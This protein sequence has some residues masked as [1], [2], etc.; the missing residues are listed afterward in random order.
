MKEMQPS[1]EE[2]RELLDYDPTT[3]ELHWKVRRNS[4]VA[5]GQLAGS[6]NNEG[7][8]VVGIFRKVYQAHRIAWLIYYGQWPSDQLDH[9]NHCRTDN[10]ITNLR[11]V[12][13]TSNLRNKRK[14][15]ANTSGTTGVYKTRAGNWIARICVGRETLNLGTF[16]SIDL[17][18]KA[19]NEANI[20]HRFHTNHG[21]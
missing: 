7:Y 16:P 5:E 8:L 19:R 6:I 20:K 14:S 3:G 2:I 18:L 17:A 1:A 9:I 11:E 4:R 15:K 10:R 21:R 12:T 13:Q